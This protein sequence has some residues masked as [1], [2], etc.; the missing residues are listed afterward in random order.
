MIMSGI[1]TI[2]PSGILCCST[3]EALHGDAEMARA[4]SRS[5]SR[6]PSVRRPGRWIAPPWMSRTVAWLRPRGGGTEK[7]VADLRGSKE[8]ILAKYS[9]LKHYRGGPER[10][11]NGRVPMEE[12]TPEEVSAHLAFMDHVAEVRTLRPARGR[13]S[14]SGSGTKQ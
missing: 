9:L 2:G 11:P 10:M 13:N 7:G 6:L 8:Q 5:L 12:W 3:A 4:A 14:S 1:L